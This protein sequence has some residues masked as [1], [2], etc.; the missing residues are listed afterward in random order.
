MSELGYK[1][2]DKLTV[3]YMGTD[4]RGRYIVSHKALFPPPRATHYHYDAL[5]SDV[6]TSMTNRAVENVVTTN[7]SEVHNFL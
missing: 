5:P 3:K 1:P 6:D 2:G 7:T 4:E